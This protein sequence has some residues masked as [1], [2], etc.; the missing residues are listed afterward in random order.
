AGAL[1]LFSGLFDMLDG[2]V[3]RIG[4][5]SSK[6]GALFDSVLDRYSEMIMFLGICY[7]LIAYHYFLSSLFAFIALIGSM[8]VSYTRARSE[9]LGIEN[10]GGVMQRP[11]RIVLI[12]VSALACGIT[13]HFIGEDY[14]YYIP[15]TSIRIF[16]TITVFTLP[17]TVMAVLTN[18]T[19]LK[20]LFDAKK[21][22]EAQK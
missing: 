10:K 14:K 1:I 7:Y 15:G 19:A 8:M 22:M 21:A 17:I 6:Y 18:I 12:G 11:E 13:A 16:E 5:M 20:R 2:Q 4:N 3:A 9:G